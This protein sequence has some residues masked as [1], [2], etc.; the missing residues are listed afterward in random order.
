ME[1]PA[2]CPIGCLIHPWMRGYVILRESPYMA[3]SGQDGR[4][5]ITH[6]PVGKHRIR[7]WHERIDFRQVPIGEIAV[8]RRRC[9]ELNIEPGVNELA[10]VMV[11]P[12]NVRS[13]R[14]DKQ[15]AVFQISPE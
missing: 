11:R 7:L 15:E 2:P 9:I 5:E 6:L 3:K 14:G 4:L 13:R 10:V 1:E 8:D 12:K